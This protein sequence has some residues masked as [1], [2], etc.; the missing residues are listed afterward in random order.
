M[1]IEEQNSPIKYMP[2]WQYLDGRV[3]SA[4][5][6]VREGAGRQGLFLRPTGRPGSRPVIFPLRSTN[7][8][9]TRTWVMPTEC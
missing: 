4:I 7:C 8:P 9:S 1:Y 3:T 5:M 6:A 2:N